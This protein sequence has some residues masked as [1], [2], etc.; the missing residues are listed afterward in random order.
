M[1]V[2]YVLCSHQ[3]FFFFPLSIFLLAFKPFNGFIVSTADE[4]TGNRKRERG[5]DTRQS[6]GLEPEAAAA[7]AKPLCVGRPLYQL[8]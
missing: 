6:G 7:R 4:M 5:S 8:S 1:N 2:L 3:A